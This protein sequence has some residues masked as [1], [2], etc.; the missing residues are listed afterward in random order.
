MQTCMVRV[1][2]ESCPIRKDGKR[3]VKMKVKDKTKITTIFNFPDEIVNVALNDSETI[4]PT[5]LELT[6]LF[7]EKDTIHITTKNNEICDIVLEDKDKLQLFKDYLGQEEFRQNEL[8]SLRRKV[9]AHSNIDSLI[10]QIGIKVD[11]DEETIL[12]GPL[13]F[14][15]EKIKENQKIVDLIESTL[16]SGYGY[17]CADSE[18]ATLEALRQIVKKATSRNIKHQ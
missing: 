10:E 1:K 14:D 4:Q 13:G 12:H 9:E 5:F 3:D 16:F 2:F 15:I 17:E 6:E 7:L 18:T 8:T 11:T